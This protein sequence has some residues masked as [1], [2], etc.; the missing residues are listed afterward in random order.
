MKPA[1][2]GCGSFFRAF[3]SALGYSVQDFARLGLY[4]PRHPVE[5]GI[6]LHGFHELLGQASPKRWATSAD[7]SAG[8]ERFGHQECHL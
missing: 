8:F 7:I 1:P 4:L 6:A 5:L 2:S 3:A